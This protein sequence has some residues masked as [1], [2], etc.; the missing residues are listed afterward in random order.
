MLICLFLRYWPDTDG[1]VGCP[2]SILPA[3]IAQRVELRMVV[4]YDEK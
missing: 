1:G 2:A 3:R 4:L